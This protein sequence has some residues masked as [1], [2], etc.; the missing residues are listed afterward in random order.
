MRTVALTAVLGL[1]L[2]LADPASAQ[3][4]AD[5]PARPA[6][7]EVVASP[8]APSLSLRSLFNAETL[9]LSHSYQ[10][11]YSAGLGGDLGLG[12]FTTSLR[13]QPSARLAGRV[14]VGVAHGATGSLANAAGFSPDRP[15]RLF[16][17]NAELA[18]RPT[19][20]S[21]I[22]LQVRQTPY[23]AACGYGGSV[24]APASQYGA[25]YGCGASGASASFSTGGGDLFWRDFPEDN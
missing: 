20:N 1:A 17:Q 6:P 9:S 11:G 19:Q 23:G 14:D 15:A 21:L 22:Q 13:W 24:Y 4:Q 2:L 8:E 7:V 18:Y 10:Y 5:V 25:G 12:V 16:L 3:F